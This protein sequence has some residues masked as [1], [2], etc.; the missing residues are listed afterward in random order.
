MTITASSRVCNG[1]GR[2]LPVPPAAAVCE[3]C[4]RVATP[5]HTEWPQGLKRWLVLQLL[6]QFWAPWRPNTEQYRWERLLRAVIAG[7]T[8]KQ[9]IVQYSADAEDCYLVALSVFAPPAAVASPS[10]D[11]RSSSHAA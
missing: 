9:R 7:R 4:G 3:H 5:L 10:P 8:W 1:C 2:L 11:S 6:E